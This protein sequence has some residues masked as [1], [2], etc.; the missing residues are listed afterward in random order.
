M[1]GAK[2]DTNTAKAKFSAFLEEHHADDIRALAADYPAR[3]TLVFDW[4]DFAAFAPK[5][6]REYQSNRQDLQPAFD[7]ALRFHDAHDAAYLNYCK[8]L[9]RAVEDPAKITDALRSHGVVSTVTARIT[10]IRDEET[11]LQNA[12]Y[13]CKACGKQNLRQRRPNQPADE[14]Y[15][16]DGC[17][18]KRVEYHLDETQ[19][20]VLT[21]VVADIEGPEHAASYGDL[22]KHKLV[23]LGEYADIAEV[24]TWYNLTGWPRFE[25]RPNSTV[26]DP[27]FE[28]WH[29][30]PANPDELFD[31]SVHE[32]H[33]P[34]K[35]VIQ[36]TTDFDLTRKHLVG[37][38]THVEDILDSRPARDLNETETKTKLI[39][40]FL[41]LLG[42]NP[43]SRAMT[44]EHHT[45]IGDVD[46]AV[47]DEDD[48]AIFMVEAK[49]AG[50]LSPTHTDQ[51]E[52][53]MTYGETDFGLL[54][55]GLTFK[56]LV[57]S[58]TKAAPS[59]V[60]TCRYEHLEEFQAEVEK[61]TQTSLLG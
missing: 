38:T 9:P 28:A 47:V 40:P 22:Q 1:S 8:A 5:L 13:E 4:N 12:A 6:A 50:S 2:F 58:R 29:A 53:Y 42:W 21:R 35:D 27:Y 30:E 59:V 24:G 23:L 49:S 15:Y 61:F 20:E 33:A 60:T 46:Y 26:A 41:E 55:D 7:E 37:Y 45:Y 56:F 19:S 32:N 54:T 17:D 43:Y 14:P 10:D 34:A 25:L 51:I 39:T 31:G 18:R 44:M 57:N 3:K 11:V 48:D 36:Q 52:K 16:C